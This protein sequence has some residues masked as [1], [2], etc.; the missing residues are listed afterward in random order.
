MFKYISNHVIKTKYQNNQN[1]RML[2]VRKRI[3]MRSFCI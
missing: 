2:S 1:S 3:R